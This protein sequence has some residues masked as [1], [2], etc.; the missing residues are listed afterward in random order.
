MY[1]NTSNFVESIQRIRRS[2]AGCQICLL[3]L[4]VSLRPQFSKEEIQST[5]AAKDALAKSLETSPDI[6]GFCIGLAR[7]DMQLVSKFARQVGEFDIQ[8]V[9]DLNILIS[10]LVPIIKQEGSSDQDKGPKSVESTDSGED[11]ISQATKKIVPHAKK[12]RNS[13]GQ[14]SAEAVFHA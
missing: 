5:N 14:F 7:S 9:E 13:S 6:V 3:V 8:V 10:R 12:A 1:F 2:K 4:C 11:S